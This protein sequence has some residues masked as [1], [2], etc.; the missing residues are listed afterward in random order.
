MHL[1]PLFD[2]YLLNWN[3]LRGCDNFKRGTAATPVVCDRERHL[4]SSTSTDFC[5]SY[6]RR[7]PIYEGDPSLASLFIDCVSPPLRAK[8]Y[9]AYICEL[10]GIHPSRVTLFLRA[11]AVR[12]EGSCAAEAQKV[13]NDEDIITAMTASL[14]SE[15]SPIMVNV[16][17]EVGAYG[18]LDLDRKSKPLSSLSAKVWSLFKWQNRYSVVY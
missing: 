1:S 18:D 16:V 6:S 13:Q 15:N 10:E 12:E 7:S 4:C 2:I 5:P 11:R 9:I 14:T 8:D 3:Q 17:L